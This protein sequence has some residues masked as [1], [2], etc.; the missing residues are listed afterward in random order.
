MRRESSDNKQDR[1]PKLMLKPI[2]DIGIHPL[3]LERMRLAINSVKGRTKVDLAYVQ[4]SQ[5]V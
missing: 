2:A 5:E 1:Y 4:N 3:S